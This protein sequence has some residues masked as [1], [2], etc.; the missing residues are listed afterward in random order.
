V[1][2]GFCEVALAD[3]RES[4]D[5]EIFRATIHSSVPSAC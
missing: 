3:A 4:A 5:A 1:C 2:E